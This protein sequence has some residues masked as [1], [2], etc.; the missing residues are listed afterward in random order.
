MVIVL[1]SGEE[2]TKPEIKFSVV[3]G[4]NNYRKVN[5]Y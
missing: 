3:N 5:I 4:Y 2:Y 1:K